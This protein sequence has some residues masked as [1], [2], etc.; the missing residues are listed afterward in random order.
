MQPVLVASNTYLMPKGV[1][2]G[3]EALREYDFVFYSSA[4]TQRPINKGTRPLYCE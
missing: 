1:P 3:I 4:Q 2:T